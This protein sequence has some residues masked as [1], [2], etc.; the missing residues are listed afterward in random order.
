MRE[1]VA[2]P[3]RLESSRYHHEVAM[4]D[5]LTALAA[6]RRE[7]LAQKGRLLYGK[8]CGTK[9]QGICAENF[10]LYHIRLEEI[11]VVQDFLEYLDQQLAELR[12]AGPSAQFV[13]TERLVNC[14]HYHL[15]RA[16]F[17]P[18]DG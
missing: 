18:A 6:R 5:S 12:A 7:F 9:G 14:I 3:G 8:Y 2:R 11:V 15:E 13:I 17:D 1:R 4:A 10:A 16:G